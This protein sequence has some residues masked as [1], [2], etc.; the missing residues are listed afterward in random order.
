MTTHCRLRPLRVFPLEESGVRNYDSPQVCPK[1]CPRG[2]KTHP[3]PADTSQRGKEKPLGKSEGYREVS[4]PAPACEASALRT[5]LIVHARKLNYLLDTLSTPTLSLC[6][7]MPRELPG[8]LPEIRR[9]HNVVAIDPGAGPVPRHLHGH[10]LGNPLVDQVPDRRSAEVVPDIPGHPAFVQAVVQALRKLSRRSPLS[11]PV[12]WGK[13][14]CSRLQT[15]RA[16][17]QVKLAPLQSQHLAVHAPAIRIGNRHGNLEVLGEM[18]PHGEEP[19]RL[20]EALTRGSLL[21]LSDD[22][23]SESFREPEHSH[24]HSEIPVDR[25]VARKPPRELTGA[26]RAESLH[27]DEVDWRGLR[28]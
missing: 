19:L 18:P 28:W 13:R 6:P 23:E 21:E 3:K 15:Q 25:A 20:E 16:G 14:C 8:D 11:R 1:M 2:P 17:L 12:R 9:T 24:Q 5:E 22:G 27:P 26:L 7:K 4:F 10:A